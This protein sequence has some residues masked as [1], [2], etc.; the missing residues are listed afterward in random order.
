MTNIESKYGDDTLYEPW[1]DNNIFFP[2]ATNLV[3]PLYSIGLTPNSVT[4]ISTMLVFLT[5]YFL[6]L[7]NKTM[8]IITY[9]LA[10]IFDCV[11]GKM[12]RKYK[13]CSDFGMAFDTV[14]DNISNFVLFI[15]IIFKYFNS[16]N[17][18][19]ILFLFIAVMIYMLSLS[20]GLNEAISSYDATGC[21][22]FYEKK[23]KQL[24]KYI[25]NNGDVLLYKL[26]LIIMNVSYNSYRSS[27]P[28][29]NIKKINKKLS[30]LKNFGP[31]NYVVFFSII[32][33]IL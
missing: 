27:F 2:I 22:N 28:H 21:D 20:L 29:Y 16:N 8:A 9:L 23:V 1:C 10:Y 7:N 14:S 5:I 18:N 6:Y 4:T 17:L 33:M 15:F 31:G 19:I 24:Q 25:D 32:M 12:A 26:Y 30:M 3:D 13:M 11:D